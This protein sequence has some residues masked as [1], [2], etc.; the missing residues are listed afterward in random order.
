MPHRDRPAHLPWSVGEH[1]GVCIML[2]CVGGGRVLTCGYGPG[3]TATSPHALRPGHSALRHRCC[4]DYLP[5]LPRALA[6]H[7][8]RRSSS[9]LRFTPPHSRTAPPQPRR[10]ARPTPAPRMP[11][12]RGTPPGPSPEPPRTDFPPPA[13]R[14]SAPSAGP[15]VPGPQPS[16]P[17]AVPA[18]RAGGFRRAYTRPRR[19]PPLARHRRSRPPQTNTPCYMRV[20]T[21]SLVL[22]V[23]SGTSCVT[24]R[25][26]RCNNG[27]TTVLQRCNN[28]VTTV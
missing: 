16:S 18:R 12:S 5:D 2:V 25:N 10:T 4:R 21:T 13:S 6:R 22:S 9:H 27:V 15:P 11:R 23:C 19:P 8:R 3:R 1:K 20:N 14:P 28:G 24:T 17:P 7:L 26:N